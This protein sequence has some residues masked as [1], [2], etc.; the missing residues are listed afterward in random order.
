MKDKRF[1]APVMSV[2]IVLMLL[3]CAKK[4]EYNITD[5]ANVPGSF[6]VNFALY[7]TKTYQFVAY[8]DTS[9]CMTLASKG[10]GEEDWKHVRLESKVGWDSHNY[11]SLAVDE[12]NIIHL[13]GNMHSSP[14]VYFRSTRPLDIHSM[15]PI[16]S[17]LGKD[18]DV[19]TYPEFLQGDDG[20]LL[21]HYRYGRSGDGYEVYNLWDAQK[22]TWSRLLDKPLIDGE[23]K[24][25]AYMQ[26]PLLGPDGRYHLLWVWRDTP[27]CATNHTLS[28]ARSQN[29]QDWESIRGEKIQLPITISDSVLQVD[30]IPIHGGLL[31]IGIKIGFD[32]NNKV[33]AG[34]HKYDKK[35]NTQLYVAGFDS[36]VWNRTQLTNW[37]YRWDFKGWGT[38]QNDLLI[39][40]PRCKNG[41]MSMDY[42]HVKYG[43]GSVQFDPAFKVIDIVPYLPDYPLFVDS[44]ASDSPGYIANKVFDNGHPTGGKKY[45]LRWETKQANGDMKPD[46]N[47]ESSV[48]Q[49]VEY[50]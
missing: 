26:G 22:Q 21:F 13:V 16:H 30:A 2:L 31:N 37:D 39:G 14:L 50:E 3:G 6:P 4:T 18:E 25:N 46:K 43:D 29:L 12:N 35:G 44:V 38:I 11:L 48:L 17:M 1:V 34:Y 40:A 45:L 36:G 33:M 47:V 27:D 5:I 23:G 8:Y 42:H 28:Y 32:C 49:I 7:T 41:V 19:T 10:L 9:H 20:Q 24:M 15:Q